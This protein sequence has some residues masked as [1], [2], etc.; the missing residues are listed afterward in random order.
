M[1]AEVDETE[2]KQKGRLEGGFIFLS[3]EG[4]GIVY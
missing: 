1:G 2:E 3:V 4:A